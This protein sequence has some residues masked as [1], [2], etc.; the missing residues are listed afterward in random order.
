MKKKK[1]KDIKVG[2]KVL[3]RET[4]FEYVVAFITDKSILIKSGEKQ[5]WIPKFYISIFDSLLSTSGYRLFKL[6][7]LPGWLIEKNNIY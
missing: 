2:D 1:V 4:G 3:L 6:N 7:A 5:Y